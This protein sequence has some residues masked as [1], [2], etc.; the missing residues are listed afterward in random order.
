MLEVGPDAEHSS[1]PRVVVLERGDLIAQRLQCGDKF[2]GGVAG[3]DVLGAVPVVGGDV[4]AD[5]VLDVGRVVGRDEKG[6][7]VR[8]VLGREDLE[9]P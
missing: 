5:E 9:P 8:V 1:Q 3:S 7:Q 6:A 2:L 4:H